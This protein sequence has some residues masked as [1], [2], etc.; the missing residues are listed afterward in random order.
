MQL[1]RDFPAH[2]GDLHGVRSWMH[3]PVRMQDCNDALFTAKCLAVITKE[4]CFY[5]HPQNADEAH[6]F[7]TSD[8]D[9][10]FRRHLS[11]NVCSDCFWESRDME[12]N[13]PRLSR[14]YACVHL[15]KS[16]YLKEA[17]CFVHL[18]ACSQSIMSDRNIFL[19]L[20]LHW[21]ICNGSHFTT[22]ISLGGHLFT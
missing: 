21:P 2:D 1:W 22:G 3:F 8:A 9:A 6:C 10:A 15:V 14:A 13:H 19:A 16:V 12:N 18:R 17:P 11:Q 4:L 7:L 5:D 20:I